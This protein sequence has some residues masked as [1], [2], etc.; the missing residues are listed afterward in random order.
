MKNAPK[1]SKKMGA[2]SCATQRI[3]AG[4]VG[5]MAMGI[6]MKVSIT[7]PSKTRSTKVAVVASDVGDGVVAP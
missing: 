5:T 4:R 6:T 2:V 3:S 7:T 1:N